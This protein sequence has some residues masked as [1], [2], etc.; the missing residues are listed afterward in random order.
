[1]RPLGARVSTWPVIDSC[2]PDTSTKPPLPPSLPARALMLPSMRVRPADVA[3]TLPPSP[4]PSALALV[5]L[6]A[7]SASSLLALNTILPPAP[8]TA[9]SALTTPLCLTS[10]P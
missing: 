1:M 10:A 6:P 9:L 5:T 8:T 3:T 7:S 4:V 2:V